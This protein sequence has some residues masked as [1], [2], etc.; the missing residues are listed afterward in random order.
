MAAGHQH[1]DV[2][3]WDPLGVARLRV[4]MIWLAIALVA[5][6]V[7]GA[8]YGHRL[9][10]DDVGLEV[11]RA[12]EQAGFVDVDVEM[13]G[14]SATLTG[15]VPTEADIDRAAETAGSVAGI[16]GITV[17]LATGEPSS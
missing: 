5:V 2:D 1:G 7:V 6:L 11:T 9:V 14:R 15:T 17:E 12:L 13:T 8:V 3:E 4:R 16:K 10:E